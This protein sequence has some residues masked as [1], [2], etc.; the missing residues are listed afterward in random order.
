[1][2]QRRVADNLTKKVKKKKIRSAE[3]SENS[4]RLIS[5]ALPVRD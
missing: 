5:N 4:I 2:Q 3:T 1:M